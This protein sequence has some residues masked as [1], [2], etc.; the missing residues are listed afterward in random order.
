MVEVEEVEVVELVVDG[1]FEEVGGSGGGGVSGGVK[2]GCTKEVSWDNRQHV[3]L[4]IQNILFLDGYR[5]SCDLNPTHFHTTNTPIS[6]SLSLSLT[7]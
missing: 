1:E 2:G 3:E 4:R 5:Q 6:I 7:H